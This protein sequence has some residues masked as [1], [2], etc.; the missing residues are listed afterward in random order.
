MKAFRTVDPAVTL[1]P[2]SSG[3]SPWLLESATLYAKDSDTVP[4]NSA[5][6]VAN[7]DATALLPGALDAFRFGGIVYGLP[8]AA[9]IVG[10]R[11]NRGAIATAGIPE[12]GPD[13]TL[14]EFELTL[15]KLAAAI[16]SGR[17]RRFVAPLPPLVG[18][19]SVTVQMPESS[20]KISS[21]LLVTEGGLSPGLGREIYIPSQTRMCG[22]DLRW[23]LAA[24][25][26][27]AS[28]FA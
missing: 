9:A 1:V 2:W 17:L 11:Y 7:F 25:W 15:A 26:Y 28:V 3:D 22:A 27:R 4:L 18:N 6:E 19:A 13:W 23:D 10:V 24:C 16:K 8:T 14:S 21:G 12:P 20:H 5:L